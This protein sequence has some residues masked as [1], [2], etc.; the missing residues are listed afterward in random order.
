MNYSKD[1]LTDE[2]RRAVV[3]LREKIS[4]IRWFWISETTA[5]EMILKEMFSIL[6]KK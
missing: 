1:V 3:Y 5:E 4:C 6:P 2:A